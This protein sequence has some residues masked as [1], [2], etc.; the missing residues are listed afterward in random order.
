MTKIVITII[1]LTFL[2]K[3]CFINLLFFNLFNLYWDVFEMYSIKIFWE[4]MKNLTE[5][6]KCNATLVLHICLATFSRRVV[7]HEVIVKFPKV[8]L[9]SFLF[10]NSLYTKVVMNTHFNSDL[11]IVFH[12]NILQWSIGITRW[13]N[14]VRLYWR[15]WYN[16]ISLNVL[17]LYNFFLKRQWCSRETQW[18][19]CT[20]HLSWWKRDPMTR[21][22]VVISR[23]LKRIL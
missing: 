1:V 21:F 20:W 23:C 10:Q 6:I 22:L 4:K 11:R 13:R 5:S 15:Q 2:F 8:Y 7:F 3:Y 18:F 16:A 14:E 12:Y 17:T 9:T 19:Y